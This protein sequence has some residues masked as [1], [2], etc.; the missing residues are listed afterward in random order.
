MANFEWVCELCG[1]GG[2][3]PLA[4][5]DLRLLPAFVSS[6]SLCRLWNCG[7]CPCEIWSSDAPSWR[8]TDAFLC[9]TCQLGLVKSEYLRVHYFFFRN[10]SFLCPECRTWERNI[11]FCVCVHITS[12]FW[13]KALL[14]RNSLEQRQCQLQVELS[15]DTPHLN[16]LRIAKHTRPCL[17]LTAREGGCGQGSSTCAILDGRT[18]A[19]P[20]DLSRSDQWFA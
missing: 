16:V 17:R 5:S 9:Q 6:S 18:V 19:G 1:G 11:F 2:A 10:K 12:K 8:L 3:V 13:S 4:L 14:T 7:W 20:T 15:Q